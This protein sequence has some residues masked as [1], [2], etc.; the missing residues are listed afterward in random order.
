MITIEDGMIHVID[1]F[2][3]C[4]FLVVNV[5]IIVKDV[6]MFFVKI[7]RILSMSEKEVFIVKKKI[8]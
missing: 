2:L 6:D 3:G 7:A 5:N 1:V 4:H 8:R